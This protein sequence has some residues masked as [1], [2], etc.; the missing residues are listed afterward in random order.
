MKTN[1][2]KRL[3]TINE[4]VHLMGYKKDLN[5]LKKLKVS[6]SLIDQTESLIETQKIVVK[7]S[8]IKRRKDNE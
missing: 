3:R 5:D 1:I 6:Q 7:I 2:K 4:I 8:K